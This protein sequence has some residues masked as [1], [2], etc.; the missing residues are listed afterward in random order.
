MR[1]VAEILKVVPSRASERQ[2]VADEV[3]DLANEARTHDSAMAVLLE[4]L[5][6]AIRQSRHDEA[7]GFIG[8]IDPRA[9]A[10][11]MT[12]RRSQ[13]WDILEVARNVL[14]FAPIAVTWFGLS[15][16]TDA[17]Q[18]LVAQKPEMVARP[19]LLLWQEAFE[20]ITPVLGFSTLALIDASLIALL[21]VLS[22]VIHI[23]A[24]VR[25]AGER[26]QA[27]VKESQIRSVLGHASGLASTSVTGGEA[28]EM[29]DQMAAE[30]RRVFER[31]IEREQQLFDL[32]GII[33]ELARSVND[34]SRAVD[35]LSK[36]NAKDDVRSR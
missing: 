12:G 13:I 28:D 21:I 10:E 32:E 25:G 5:A 14:V 23:R 1:N 26:V 20:G 34:L 8:A 27:V 22:L 19:F 36:S 2:Q 35:T 24:D 11:A 7:K 18:K 4:R 9:T 3:A 30:E 16:A 6:D 17:Y 33:H 15:T 31:A 29:L